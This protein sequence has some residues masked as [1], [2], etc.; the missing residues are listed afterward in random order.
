[1]CGLLL[2]AIIIRW[3]G[4]PSLQSLLPSRRKGNDDEVVL[5]SARI[6][7]H[8]CSGWSGRIIVFMILAVW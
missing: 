5:M 6:I 3:A 2:F 1:M 8:S 4:H 7:A